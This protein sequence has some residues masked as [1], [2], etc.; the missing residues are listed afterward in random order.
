ML[1][2]P[3]LPC[4]EFVFMRCDSEIRNDPD[5]C[6]EAWPDFHEDAQDKYVLSRM[7]YFDAEEFYRASKALIDD[8]IT[9]WYFAIDWTDNNE[10]N[11]YTICSGAIDPMD[12]DEIIAP[13]LF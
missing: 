8:P 1:T 12:A 3:N 10:P 6:R 2:K 11:G 7:Q 4:Y 5:I 13:Y 9:M